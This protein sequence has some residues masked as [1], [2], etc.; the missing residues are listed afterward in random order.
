MLED[1]KGTWT[2]AWECCS[3]VSSYLGGGGYCV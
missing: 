1:V 2:S 3:G